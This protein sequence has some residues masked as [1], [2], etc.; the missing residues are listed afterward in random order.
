M[1]TG[2]TTEAQKKR[3]PQLVQRLIQGSWA[4]PPTTGTVRRLNVDIICPALQPKADQ[5]DDA[6]YSPPE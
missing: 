1:S 4:E 5:E 2:L 3:K 6:H